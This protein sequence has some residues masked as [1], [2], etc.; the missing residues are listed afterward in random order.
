MI[1]D[2]DLTTAMKLPLVI[3]T[4][5]KDVLRFSRKLKKYNIRRFHL[6]H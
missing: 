1:P 2:A 4:Y 3:E 5:G 6:V